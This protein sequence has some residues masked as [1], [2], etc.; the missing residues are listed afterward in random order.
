MGEW[1]KFADGKITPYQEVLLSREPA[2]HDALETLRGVDL[3]D[4]SKASPG[5]LAAT[6]QL[7]WGVKKLLF[8]LVVDGQSYFQQQ[9]AGKIDPAGSE[10]PHAAFVAAQ[11]EW[12]PH[13]LT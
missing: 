13:L 2:L 1:P 4:L 9:L 3:L 5:Q 8:H 7:A 6:E 10:I 11:Q 12:L